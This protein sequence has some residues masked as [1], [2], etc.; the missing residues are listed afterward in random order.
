MIEL[1]RNIDFD[2][3]LNRYTLD[4]IEDGENET[5]IFDTKQ[6]AYREYGKLRRAGAG[7]IALELDRSC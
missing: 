3:R 6:A 7:I 2:R 5:L 1:S 4:I